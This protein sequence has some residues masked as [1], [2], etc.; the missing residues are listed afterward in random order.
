MELDLERIK[1]DVQ[2]ALQNRPDEAR[3]G[4]E[5]RLLMRHEDVD[6]LVAE[7]ERLR[8]QESYWR[9]LTRQLA[10]FINRISEEDLTATPADPTRHTG[11]EI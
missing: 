11:S 9:K 10:E 1:R 4:Y 2:Q 3:E 7:I 8:A 6:A 5:W